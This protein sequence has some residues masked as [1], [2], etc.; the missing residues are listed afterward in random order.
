MEFTVHAWSSVHV[1]PGA[2]GFIAVNLLELFC[3]RAHNE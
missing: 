1:G 3:L 2:R